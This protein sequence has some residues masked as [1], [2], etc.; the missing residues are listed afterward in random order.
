MK[1]SGTSVNGNRPGH[2]PKDLG[3]QT[4]LGPKL[5]NLS[6]EQANR[7][8]RGIEPFEI[9]EWV[10][11]YSRKPILTTNF[12]P[13]S[14]SLLHAVTKVRKDISVIWCDTGYN[15]PHTYRFARDLMERLSLNMHI[16]TPKHTPGFRDVV[17]GIPP[18]ESEE[19]KAFT[20]EVKLDPFHRALRE[21]QPD[22]W[23]TNLRKH[24]TAHREN[25]DILHLNK[26]G[27]LKVS[28]FFYYDEEKLEHYLERFDLPNEK[29]YFDPTKV[30][31]KRECGLHL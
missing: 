8:L 20:Q 7:Q 17:M 2:N 1:D 23:F 27:I 5:G 9:I 28:P 21:H 16:Y 24:Q 14:A 12:G 10:L 13:Y 26:T 3:D 29:K 25:L 4:Y 31:D 15:T 19:H 11:R 6:L 18:V 22:V 30:L